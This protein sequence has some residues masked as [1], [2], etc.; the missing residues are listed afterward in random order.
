MEMITEEK[1]APSLWPLFGM[2][3]TMIHDEASNFWGR[4]EANMGTR[5]EDELMW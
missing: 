4:I 5:N 3:F 1:K 2:L